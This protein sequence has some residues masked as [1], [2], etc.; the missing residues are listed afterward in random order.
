MKHKCSLKFQ[1]LFLKLFEFS[2]GTLGGGDMFL[3]RGASLP[4]VFQFFFLLL[5]ILLGIIVGGVL[6]FA[7]RDMVRKYGFIREIARL[8]QWI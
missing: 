6:A 5:V 2:I 7:Y 1:I 4:F 3:A 8:P